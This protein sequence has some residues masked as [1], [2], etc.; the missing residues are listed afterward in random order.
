MRTIRW[1][2]NEYSRALV[3]TAIGD[4]SDTSYGDIFALFS[5]MELDKVVDGILWSKHGKKFL[6][7]EVLEE[8][9]ENF[10]EYSLRIETYFMERAPWIRQNMAYIN[11]EYNPIEN[12]SQIERETLSMDRKKKTRDITNQEKPYERVREIENPEVITEQYAQND[13]VTEREQQKSTVTQSVAPFDSDT[14]H[15]QNKTEDEPGKI[16]NTEKAYNRKFKTPQNTVTETESLEAIKEVTQKIEDAAFI[17]QDRRELTRSGNI[18]VQTA[19]QMML[20]D[21]EFWKNNRWLS[22]IAEDIVN[23]LCEEVLYAL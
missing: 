15:G 7:P 13:I 16:T 14:F 9:S 23:L 8:I 17:D 11:A 22:Q 3:Q 20:L 2:E 6:L 21:E 5:E 18:G 10:Y 12:Y 19:A 1:L 4:L